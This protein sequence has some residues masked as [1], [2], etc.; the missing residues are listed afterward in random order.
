MPIGKELHIQFCKQK[1]NERKAPSGAFLFCQNKIIGEKEKNLKSGSFW[2]DGRFIIASS[3]EV[4]R[5][6]PGRLSREG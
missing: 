1:V 4:A 6:E 3:E 5:G 2:G